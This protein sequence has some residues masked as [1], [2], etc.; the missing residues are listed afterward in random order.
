MV[1]TVIKSYSLSLY[2]YIFVLHGL[3]KIFNFNR[4]IIFSGPLEREILGLCMI[5]H[6]LLTYH[7]ILSFPRAEMSFVT[8][9]TIVVQCAEH[10]TPIAMQKA[11]VGCI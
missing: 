10:L 1:E 11:L 2:I 8:F 6:K 5:V 3:N 4:L 7:R 9:V